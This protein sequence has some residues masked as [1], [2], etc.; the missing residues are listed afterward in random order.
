MNNRIFKLLFSLTLLS[1]LLMIVGCGSGG[2]Q[3][4][5]PQESPEAAVMRLSN[6]WRYSTSA[7][8]IEVDSNNN[9]VRQATADDNTNGGSSGASSKVITLTD[10]SGNSYDLLLIGVEVERVEN[11]ASIASITT[12]FVYETGYLLIVF[13][14]EFEEGQW[15]IENITITDNNGSSPTPTPTPDPDPDPDP[16]PTTDEYSVSG[17]IRDTAGKYISGAAVQAFLINEDENEF[18]GSAT[19]DEK[20]YY[21]IDLND[22][23][24]GDYLLVVTANGME[25]QTIKV[26]VKGSNQ[27]PTANCRVF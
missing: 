7:P 8:A 11:T 19:T 22:T 17:Y 24:D 4:V 18:A 6:S 2:G 14:L 15:W 5:L 27:N 12:H 26:T 23:K 9:F 3:S 16:D 25:S 20:G 13:N 10:F 1:V 21:K